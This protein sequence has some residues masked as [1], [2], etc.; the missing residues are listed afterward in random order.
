MIAKITMGKYNIVMLTLNEL[1]DGAVILING[2]MG[3]GKTTFVKG[4]IPNA[5]SPTFTIVNQYIPNIFHLDLYRLEHPE[6][7]YNLG[8]EDILAP[9]NIVFIEWAERLPKNW[10]RH[11]SGLIINVNI[12]KLDN[13]ERKI[14]ITKSHPST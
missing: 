9:G 2:E 8:L 12:S 5:T 4:I 11:L 6:E 1:E 7:F 3:A 13:D 14:E 10:L